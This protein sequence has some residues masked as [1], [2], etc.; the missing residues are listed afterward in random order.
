MH[1]QAA[2]VF[3]ANSALLKAETSKMC[4]EFL[5]LVVAKFT[6]WKL[7]TCSVAC[8]LCRSCSTA[9]TVSV[10]DD[11]TCDKHVRVARGEVCDNVTRSSR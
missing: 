11:K 1:G 8:S 7:R 6:V 5:R 3:F 4:K 2:S 9:R 10:D